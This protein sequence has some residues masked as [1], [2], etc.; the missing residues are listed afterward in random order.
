MIEVKKYWKFDLNLILSRWK[1]KILKEK[2]EG[3]WE[4]DKWKI[5][6]WQQLYVPVIFI[7]PQFSN[8]NIISFFAPPSLRPSIKI[9]ENR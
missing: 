3:F 1:V 6:M 2:A 4:D 7:L 8:D 9:E 5:K